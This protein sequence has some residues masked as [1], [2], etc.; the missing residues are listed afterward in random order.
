MGFNLYEIRYSRVGKYY[1]LLRYNYKECGIQVPMLQIGSSTVVW[2]LLR[3]DNIVPAV[4]LAQCHEDMLW[5]R[6]AAPHVLILQLCEFQ[7]GSYKAQTIYHVDMNHSCPLVGG[8]VGSRTGLNAM[9]MEKSPA[10]ILNPI[11][12]TSDRAIHSR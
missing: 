12:S 7:M 11:P 3:E 1:V 5:C 6:R 10:G 2:Q 8:W 9:E 4:I